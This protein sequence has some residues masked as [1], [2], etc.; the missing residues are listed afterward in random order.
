MHFDATYWRKAILHVRTFG[1]PPPEVDA[2]AHYY[3]VA[4]ERY[5]AARL[6]GAPILEDVEFDADEEGF[7]AA[8]MLFTYGRLDVVPY[9][10]R[11]HFD[12]LMNVRVLKHCIWFLIPFPP[13]IQAERHR[14]VIEE[15]SPTFSWLRAHANRLSF[16]PTLRRY[17]LLP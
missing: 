15:Q 16:D 13:A 17:I 1:N 5:D 14:E 3:Q 2:D 8:L 11:Q 10:L 6:I 4:N 7:L 12:P 9:I